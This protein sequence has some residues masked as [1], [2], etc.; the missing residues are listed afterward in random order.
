ML[1][2]YLLFFNRQSADDLL[3][4]G[5]YLNNM[6]GFRCAVEDLSCSSP[7]PNFLNIKIEANIQCTAERVL[8]AELSY[9]WGM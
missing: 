5:M 7:T 9:S 8:W 4:L 1:L 3:M 6:L 2:L